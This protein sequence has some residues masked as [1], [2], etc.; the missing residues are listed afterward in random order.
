MGRFKNMMMEMEEWGADFTGKYISPDC[1]SDS[2]LVKALTKLGNSGICSYSGK[3]GVVVPMNDATDYVRRYILKYYDD[4]DQCDLYLANSFLDKGEENDEDSKFT[5]F[6]PYLVPKD[7]ACFDDT[8]ELLE[9]L[10]LYTKNEELNADLI[11]ALGDHWWI[12]KEPF[13]I[14]L[15]D[16]LNL[17]WKQ[18]SDDVMHRQRFTFLSKK[19]FC[20]EPEHTDNG[21]LD[22]LTEIEG[23]ITRHSLCKVIDKHTHLYR[24]RPLIENVAHEFKEI[25]CPPDSAAKQNRMSP[26]GISMFYAAFDERTPLLEGSYKGDGK[27]WFLTG[28]FIPKKNLNVLD[29]TELPSPITF[30]LEGFEE[31][32]FLNAFHKEITRPI[33]R[34]NR[35]H[36]EYVPSQVFTESLRYMYKGVQLDGMIY[37]SSLVGK[38][39][40]VLFCNQEESYKMLNAVKIDE[41]DN[42]SFWER[43]C[44][45]VKGWMKRLTQ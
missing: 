27:G 22:I 11:E 26:A 2:N 23:I 36:S 40:I 14:P 33:K 5:S 25:T 28:D 38:K 10:D 19:E 18:F 7:C 15:G 8:A 42:R 3:N 21:L 20:G 37:N 29:L 41:I 34:D 30:W 6:G 9:E 24:V 31:I 17:K 1:F 13:V 44:F 39:N 45:M 32:A 12:E 16:E 4:P 35:I 43:L